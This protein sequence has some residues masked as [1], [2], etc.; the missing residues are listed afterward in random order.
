VNE[1]T[2]NVVRIEPQSGSI[3]MFPVGDGPYTYSDFTG[4]S[5]MLQFA[6]GVYRHTFQPCP[7]GQR[8]SWQQVILDKDEPPGTKVEVSVRTGDDLATLQAA[9]WFGPWG[10]NP[11]PLQMPPGP[12]PDGVYLEVE[13]ELSTNGD[14]TPRVRSMT[15]AYFCAGIP[16]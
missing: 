2:D 10:L 12:V 9:P 14:A 8:A 1:G 11:A 13:L 5:L 15:I 7:P 16:E 4:Y 3:A 6:P